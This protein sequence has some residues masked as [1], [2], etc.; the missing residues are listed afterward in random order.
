MGELTINDGIASPQELVVLVVLVGSLGP[1]EAGVGLTRAWH[2]RQVLLKSLRTPEE[3]Q[4]SRA[5]CRVQHAMF[6]P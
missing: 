4:A 5:S 6:W 3:L 2:V 1:G